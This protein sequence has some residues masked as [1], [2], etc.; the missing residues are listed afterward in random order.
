[1][2]YEA[3]YKSNAIIRPETGTDQ[4]ANQNADQAF[5]LF[6]GRLKNCNDL[7][8]LQ[9]EY[10]ADRKSDQKNSHVTVMTYHA[11]KGLEFDRVYLPNLEYGKVPHGR[12][13]TLQ[14]LEEERRMFYVA[15]T[16]AKENLWLLYDNSQTVSPFLEELKDIEKKR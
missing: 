10:E 13:L 3:Y 5:E 1:M 12:M 16:R 14:E 7:S 2:G 4:T 8:A 6:L 11:S 15:L 9:K